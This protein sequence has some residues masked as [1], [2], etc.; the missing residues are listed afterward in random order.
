MIN[1]INNIY[2]RYIFIGSH[3]Y[4]DIKCSAILKI[5]D[6]KLKITN[7]KNSPLLFKNRVT[8]NETHERELVLENIGSLQKYF[9]FDYLLAA[10]L[11][12][13]STTLIYIF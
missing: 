6:N 4:V 8:N 12:L 11:G 2:A 3:Q 7:F 1:K 5:E 13:V 10:C 9:F